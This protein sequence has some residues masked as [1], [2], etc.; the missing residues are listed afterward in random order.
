MKGLERWVEF[1][2]GMGKTWIV[3][4]HLVRPWVVDCDCGVNILAAGV[5]A[6]VEYMNLNLELKKLYLKLQ[7]E[8]VNN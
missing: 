1:L 4:L 3:G 7:V 8:M 5:P 2:F 6:L